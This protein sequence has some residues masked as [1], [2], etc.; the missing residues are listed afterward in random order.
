MGFAAFGLI[1]LM[2]V[3]MIYAILSIPALNGGPPRTAVE[4]Q[5]RVLQGALADDPKNV[6]AW[7]EYVKTL[8][9]LGQYSAARRKIEEADAALGKRRAEIAVESARLAM[10]EDAM[11]QA[12]KSGEQALKLAREEAAKEAEKLARAGVLS[13]PD[14][15]VELKAQLLLAEIYS[16]ASKPEKVLESYT[17]AL[18]L[19]PTMADVLVERA[20]LYLA[21]GDRKKAIGDLKKALTFIPDY[22][23]ALSLLADVE[24]Q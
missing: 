5:V 2:L 3:V 18:E 19:D 15:R 10:L 14:P 12:V 7:A 20:N 23:P 4:R 9:A 21:S 16:R 11:D 17:A 13:E 24:R 22:E 8:S 6:E 1:A